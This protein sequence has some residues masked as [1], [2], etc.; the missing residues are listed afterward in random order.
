MPFT[1]PGGGQ[2]PQS[3]LQLM[4]SYSRAGSQ[5][6]G[7]RFGTDQFAN[8][9]NLGKSI[10]D[11]QR[12]PNYVDRMIDIKRADQ[13]QAN[14][15][16]QQA[17]TRRSQDIGMGMAGLNT[18]TGGL[19]G[20]QGVIPGIQDLGGATVGDITG[21]FSG[22]L[23]PGTSTAFTTPGFGGG[24]LGPAKAAGVAGSPDLTGQATPGG[25]AFDPAAI[26]GGK[27]GQTP[28]QPHEKF[29]PIAKG[30]GANPDWAEMAERL[31]DPR[32]QWVQMNAPP[33]LQGVQQSF[34]L[35]RGRV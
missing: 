12:L 7:A 17:L 5:F 26:S 6:R 11:Y 32:F 1:L 30:A 4:Q 10:S 20:N 3:I 22:A 15:S 29:D 34:S 8:Q 2:T 14:I 33:G 24:G 28:R 31:M 35:A 19:F 9:V 13:N 18:L 27:P 21:E 25:A 23:A 16:N